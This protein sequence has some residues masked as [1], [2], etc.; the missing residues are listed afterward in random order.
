MMERIREEVLNRLDQTRELT[1]GEILSCIDEVI[2]Q[3]SKREYLP[4]VK[5]GQMR[6][7]GL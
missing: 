3:Y 6:K 4:L 2:V 7:G 1:D 5:R